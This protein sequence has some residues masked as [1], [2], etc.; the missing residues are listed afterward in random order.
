[1]GDR[2]TACAKRLDLR[3]A[4]KAHLP[5]PFPRVRIADDA[6]PH[7]K[8][9]LFQRL[10]LRAAPLARGNRYNLSQSSPSDLVHA[11]LLLARAA[12]R[13]KVML[14]RLFGNH[15]PQLPEESRVIRTRAQKCAQ[16]KPRI[17]RKA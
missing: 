1:M 13:F 5:V 4:Q 7:M 17:Q 8:E 10:L 15:L 14:A 2:R 12:R 16:V 11:P 9:R 6:V 3:R